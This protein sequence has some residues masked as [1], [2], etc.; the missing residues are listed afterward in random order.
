VTFSPT[1][2]SLSLSM[3]LLVITCALALSM[4]PAFSADDLKQPLVV[5][6]MRQY[7]INGASRIHLYLYGM[8]GSFQRAL[9]NDP[10]FDDLDPVFSYQG[11]SVRFTR[12]PADKAHLGQAGSYVLNLASG[13]LR[14]YDPKSDFFNR[15][16]CEELTGA[17]SKLS[18]GWLDL[19][20]P[21]YHSPDGKYVITQTLTGQ[22]LSDAPDDAGEHTYSVQVDGKA[23]VALAGLPGFIPTQEL[24]GY[25]SFFIG[26][27]SPYVNAAGMPLVFMRHHLG[28]TDG[29]EIWALD[30]TTMTGAKI[31]NNGASIYHPRSAPGV[32]VVSDARRQ[33]LGSTGH[34]V[35]CSYLEWWDAR[36]KEIRFGPDLSVCY[37]AAVFGGW[38]QNVIM[39]G[40]D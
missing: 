38:N 36:L 20:I 3:R 39:P 14:R 8:D 26:N 29:E 1:I 34:T 23:P 13:A 2:S 15:D 10:G 40:R 5:I 25:E 6:S 17:F 31:S 35:D 32:F 24:D 19:D 21:P 9:T 33:P 12:Q 16:P 22:H 7:L 30:L 11:D 27:G 18:Q 37:S 4:L 28:S